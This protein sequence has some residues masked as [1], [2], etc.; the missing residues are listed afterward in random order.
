M[1]IPTV[2][3]P[4]VEVAARK[5]REAAE[6][7]SFADTPFY[8]FTSLIEVNTLEAFKELVFGLKLKYYSPTDHIVQNTRNILFGIDE[9]HHKT[10]RNIVRKV[11]D[12]MKKAFLIFMAKRNTESF[13]TYDGNKEVFLTEVAKVG[14]PKI[15]RMYP[16]LDKMYPDLDKMYPDLNKKDKKDISSMEKQFPFIRDSE[17]E[18]LF[19]GLPI[20][21]GIERKEPKE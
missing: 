20:F 3:N 5:P 18:R 15:Q 1:E 10:I 11:I 17:F 4:R 9:K 19:Q 16:D 12:E 8:E 7:S 14:L 21:V 6:A 13:Q 2:P